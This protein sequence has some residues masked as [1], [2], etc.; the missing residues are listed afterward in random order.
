MA[1][2]KQTWDTTSYV[3]PTRMN[4]IEDG[5]KAVDNVS[6]KVNQSQT[7][8]DNLAYRMLASKSANDN[9]ELDIVRKTG[10]TYNPSRAYMVVNKQHSE[11]SNQNTGIEIGNNKASGTEGNNAGVM[12]LYGKGTYYGQF[13]DSNDS[14][15]ANRT[16]ELPNKNGV[17]ALTSDITNT[18]PECNK[19]TNGT[20]TLQ[21]VVNN[22]VKTYSW[23]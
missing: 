11:T 3:N 20:Y 4:H 7:T 22:G 12:R 18:I 14:L 1:Y 16:Y 15:S 23:V 2:T 9:A 13:Y 8:T 5:I 17:L 10:V 21:C 6:G 19:T